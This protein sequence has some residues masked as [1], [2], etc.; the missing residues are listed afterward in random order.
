MDCPERSPVLAYD[1]GDPCLTA[2][3]WT[4][5]C[6]PNLVG[7]PNAGPKTSD[8]WFNTGA[9][10]R[11]GQ[12]EF[13]SAPRN[14]V[15]GPSLKNVDISFDKFFPLG[16]RANIQL[17]FEVYNLLNTANLGIPTVDIASSRLRPHRPHGHAGS[18]VPVRHQGSVLAEQIRRAAGR[19]RGPQPYSSAAP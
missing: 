14:P 5:V 8:E 9:F 4:P 11:T 17:R 13:G 10:E 19:I 18:G 12:G 7:D 15:R 2:G 6:R 16:D 3:N 1:S